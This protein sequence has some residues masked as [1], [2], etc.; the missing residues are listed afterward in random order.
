MLA[1]RLPEH[2][3]RTADAD[4]LANAS[5][6]LFPTRIIVTGPVV[7]TAQLWAHFDG[8]FRAEGTMH[9]LMMPELVSDRSSRQYEVHGAATPL[10]S[11]ALEGLLQGA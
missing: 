10:L 8:L 9:G 1:A 4:A 3:C 6:L 11:K 7:A 5:R 2:S